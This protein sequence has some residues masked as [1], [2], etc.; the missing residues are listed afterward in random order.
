MTAQQ[1]PFGKVLML[2]RWA[3]A[4]ESPSADALSSCSCGNRLK[5]GTIKAPNEQ[6][7]QQTR[8]GLVLSFGRGK[9]AAIP[10]SHP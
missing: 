2:D 4:T 6:T 10:P 1:P 5:E 7:I 8:T 9:P 3:T